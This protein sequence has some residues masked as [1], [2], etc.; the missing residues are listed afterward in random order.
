[1][2]STELPFVDEH[3]IAI[4]AAADVAW[5]ALVLVVSAAF[6][7]RGTE[8]VAGLLGCEQRA[9]TGVAGEVGS[10]IP[11]FRVADARAPEVLVL[12]GR[13]RYSTYAL[14][15]RID[16]DGDG[17]RL[18]A[19]TR[20]EFPGWTGRAYRTVVIGSRGHVVVV[21]RLLRSVKHRAERAGAEP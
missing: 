13:H 6:A 19:E 20:A 15:L 10:T 1:M 12:E 21:R 14:T 11:G 4:D 3:S 7:G 9:A 17:S 2:A 18:R 8:R 16:C 5:S